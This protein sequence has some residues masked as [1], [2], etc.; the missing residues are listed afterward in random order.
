ME[1]ILTMEKDKHLL[2]MQKGPKAN[3]NLK[4]KKQML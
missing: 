1:R 3:Y 4:T 2:I